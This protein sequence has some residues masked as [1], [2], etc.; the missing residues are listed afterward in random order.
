MCDIL[1]YVPMEEFLDKTET[2]EAKNPGRIYMTIKNTGNGKKS[3]YEDNTSLID[4]FNSETKK[5]I[6]ILNSLMER[7]S[8]S[9]DKE[10][11]KSMVETILSDAEKKH[12]YPISFSEFFKARFSIIVSVC[13]FISN[14]QVDV[15]ENTAKKIMEN[16]INTLK[17]QIED[18]RK[19]LEEETLKYQTIIA[20]LNETIKKE[21]DRNDILRKCIHEF[22]RD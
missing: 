18:G 2:V 12:F 3:C 14:L 22:S 20:E 13:D 4:D 19:T 15:Q 10:K 17:A 11:I 21:R 8:D 9:D 5:I 16:D 7:V 1:T 6:T